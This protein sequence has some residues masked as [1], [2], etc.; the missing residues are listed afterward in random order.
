MKRRISAVIMGA[1]CAVMLVLNL[2]A[3]CSRAFSDWYVQHVF[4]FFSGL[5]SRVSG[6]FPF[7][8]GEVLIC[9]AVIVGVPAILAFPF[10]MGFAKAHRGQIARIYGMGI[11][12]ILTWLFTV[13]TLHFFLLYHA[14]PIGEQ[15]YPDAPE[16]Y[17]A[18]EI[19]PVIERMIAETN[20]LAECVARDENGYFVLTDDL[21]SGAKSAMLELSETFPQFS[22][23]Y[24][25]AKAIHFSYVMSHQSILGIYY[26]FTMEANYNRDICPINLPSTV[27]HELTHLKGN[28]LEDEANF[29]AF[30]ACISSE[31]ADFRYSGYIQ[32][33]E[34]MMD[35]AWELDPEGTLAGQLSGQAW[36]DMYKFVPEGYWEEEEH[37]LPDAIP[38]EVVEEVSAAVLDTSLKV[39]G[40]KDGDLSYGRMVDLILDYYIQDAN[41]F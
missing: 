25:D 20:A 12:G 27:C 9:L 26:P 2:L 17:T 14:T 35:L 33:M 7:S 18:E 30:L 40:V 10:L 38:E 16:V 4:P 3:W 5:W 23:Y 29:L 11:G 28:I 21:Q 31:S 37:Q 34:Y 41:A 8:L 19:R 24:P 15:Y 13:L 1:V 32:A 39:N 22:G 36:M 6:V